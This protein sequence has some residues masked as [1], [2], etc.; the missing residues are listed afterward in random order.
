LNGLRNQGFAT[1]LMAVDS[2]T[3]KAVTKQTANDQP[4]QELLICGDDK[5][6]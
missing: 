4:N 1:V 2:Q 6:D 3:M 5:S